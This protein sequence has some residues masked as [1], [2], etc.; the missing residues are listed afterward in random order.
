MDWAIL[1][2]QI[3]GAV[4]SAVAAVA[5]WRAAQS[6]H[7]ATQIA[8][9]EIRIQHEQLE[10]DRKV[11][12]ESKLPDLV[13]VFRSSGHGLYVDISNYGGPATNVRLSQPELTNETNPWEVDISSVF[14]EIHNASAFQHGI[15]VIRPKETIGIHVG[16][17][18]LQQSQN[19]LANEYLIG[20][21]Y[22]GQPSPEPTGGAT[23]SMDITYDQGSTKC[24]M[25]LD[26]TA[27]VR[28]KPA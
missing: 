5:A 8:R 7:S 22:I 16:Q 26:K 3:A 6:A 4:V 2:V 10:H 23:F 19:E 20:T 25:F 9:E 15:D 11:I 21:G 12:E 17:Y 1:V 28:S 24:R 14:H 27:F 18:T 13:S